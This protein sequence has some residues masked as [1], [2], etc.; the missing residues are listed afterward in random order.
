MKNIKKI[1]TGMMLVLALTAFTACGERTDNNADETNTAK[2]N[3]MDNGDRD[4]NMDNKDAVPDADRTDDNRTDNN[5]TSA[6]TDTKNDNTASENN[7]ADD[8]TVAGDRTDDAA[9]GTMDTD[10][11]NNNTASAP[12]IR[13]LTEMMIPFPVSWETV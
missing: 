4:N 10:T 12:W 5:G 3:V 13:V 7:A 2:D 1:I 9:D 11:K 6:D 8:N